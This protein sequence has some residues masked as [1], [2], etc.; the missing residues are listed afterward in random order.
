[1]SG[2]AGTRLMLAYFLVMAGIVA[3]AISLRRYFG[4]PARIIAF[5][6]LTIF[7]GL[8]LGVGPDWYSYIEY[9]NYLVTGWATFGLFDEPLFSLLSIAADQTGIG[10]IGVNLICAAIYFLGLLWLGSKVP[11]PWL[12]VAVAFCYYVPALP[13]GIIRQAAAVGICYIVVATEKNVPLRW[14][15]GLACIAMG[16]HVSAVVILGLVM[17]SIRIPLWQRG[18]LGVLAIGLAVV[19]N[20][21]ELGMFS[22]YGERYVGEGAAVSATAS[23]F[24][25]ALVGVPG[26]WYIWNWRRLKDCD[27]DSEMMLMASICSV[28]LVAILPIS[29][30]AV[31]RLAMYFSF[32][33]MVAAGVVVAS[34]QTHQSRLFVTLGITIVTSAIMTVWLL[35]AENSSPYQPYR[36]ILTEDWLV[37]QAFIP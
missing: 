24:H 16:F 14:R 8:R 18:L 6:M 4:W 35:F 28:G 22:L 31:T 23:L 27:L 29:S 33:P 17:A 13:M 26:A 37:Q 21:A 5:A 30:V 20:V 12:L 19:F 1:M 10:I 15:I 36:S 34:L 7:C 9:Y 32:V 2:C 3:C 11:Y 25:W